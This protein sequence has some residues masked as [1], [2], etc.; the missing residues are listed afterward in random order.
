M[1]G[2]KGMREIVERDCELEVPDGEETTGV[3][4]LEEVGLKIRGGDWKVGHLKFKFSRIP[5]S[6]T[7]FWGKNIKY[8]KM[9]SSVIYKKALNYKQHNCPAAEKQ[10]GKLYVTI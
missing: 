7:M 2:A 3:E 5:T 6:R 9:F 10:Q 8:G 1:R 4:V